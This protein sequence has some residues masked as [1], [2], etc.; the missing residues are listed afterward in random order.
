ML[1]SLECN[2]PPPLLPTGLGYS[3]LTPPPQPTPLLG[4]H[5]Q[6]RYWGGYSKGWLRGGSRERPGTL[7]AHL[8]PIKVLGFVFF[9]FL[10][11]S[12]SASDLL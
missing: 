9:S 10:A 8:P 12:K 1:S 4:S 6:T 3:K 2:L 11:S 7:P 5:H